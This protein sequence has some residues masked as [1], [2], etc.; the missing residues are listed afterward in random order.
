MGAAV[1]CWLTE[2]AV[3]YATFAALPATL[4]ELLMPATPRIRQLRR[5]K[6]LFTLAMNTIRLHLEE[7]DRLTQQPQLRET[8]DAD[9]LF[10]QQ[11]IDQ[12]VGL[13]TGHIM[14][15]FRCPAQQAMHLLGELQ[16]D[17]KATISVADLRQVPFQYALGLPPEL[18]TNQQP[19]ADE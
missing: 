3:A 9:L 18:L 7:H 10:I 14:R 13:A 4:P 19:A 11:N 5:D 16:A 12:W 17:L 15:K 1:G 2:L 6:T 8:P